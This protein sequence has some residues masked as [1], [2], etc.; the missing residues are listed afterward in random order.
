MFRPILGGRAGLKLPKQIILKECCDMTQ[1]LI[2]CIVPP[3]LHFSSC[4]GPADGDSA[5]AEVIEVDTK[6]ARSY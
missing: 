2:G 1:E 4:S 3:P 5:W 6:Y